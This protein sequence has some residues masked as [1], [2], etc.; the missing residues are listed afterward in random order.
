LSEL[1][2][3]LVSKSRAVTVR[4]PDELIVKKA[5]SVPDL[6]HVTDSFAEKVWTAVVFSEIDIELVEPVADDGPVIVGAVW[7]GV[8]LMMTTPVPPKPP[9]PS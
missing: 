8:Y 2:S 1:A 6:D 7:S 4:A 3:D 9:L 5:A